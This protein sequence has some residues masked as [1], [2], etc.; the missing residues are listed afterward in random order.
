MARALPKA[1][2]LPSPTVALAD[3]A[4]WISPKPIDAAVML[5]NTL[6][7]Q[8]HFEKPVLFKLVESATFSPGLSM[9]S[10]MTLVAV[11]LALAMHEFD[12][13]DY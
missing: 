11:V 1:D 10:S 9:V 8:N 3:L 12:S 4:Y 5:Y 2:S 6:D 13:K 7:A